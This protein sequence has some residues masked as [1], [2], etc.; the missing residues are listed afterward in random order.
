[1]KR[2]TFQAE[3]RASPEVTRK[4]PSVLRECQFTVWPD[5]QGECGGEGEKGARGRLSLRKTESSRGLQAGRD[6][7]TWDFQGH[8]DGSY[9][10]TKQK[11]SGM[12]GEEERERGGGR[13]R[14]R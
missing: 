12:R 13:E 6:V 7:T 9:V 8:H 4:K 14:E 11:G 1:M 5:A 2:S 3:R 10:E